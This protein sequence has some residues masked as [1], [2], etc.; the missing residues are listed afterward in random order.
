MTSYGKQIICHPR[1]FFLIW[2]IGAEKRTA[3]LASTSISM[4]RIDLQAGVIKHACDTTAQWKQANYNSEDSLVLLASPHELL[5]SGGV[6]I[7][8]RNG[9]KLMR[10]SGRPTHSASSKM[11]L[12]PSVEETHIFNGRQL[13]PQRAHFSGERC[14]LCRQNEHTRRRR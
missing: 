13:P 6:H 10:R 12:A 8:A 14:G 1:L 5:F 4:C 7:S 3:N 9:V 11:R 2:V